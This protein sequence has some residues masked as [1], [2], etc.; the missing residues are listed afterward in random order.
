[1]SLQTTET[2]S[3]FKMSA[4]LRQK[5]SK[6]LLWRY[7]VRDFNRN[8]SGLVRQGTADFRANVKTLYVETKAQIRDLKLF[9]T[10]LASW[11]C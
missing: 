2:Q 1:M 6:Y 10:F 7:A 8:V 9:G 4:K 3:K 11:T 5:E